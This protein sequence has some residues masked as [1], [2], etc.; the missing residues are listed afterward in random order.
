MYI[1]TVVEDFISPCRL[2]KTKLILKVHLEKI[3]RLIC[4]TILR[5]KVVIKLIKK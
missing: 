5:S 4:I 3:V 2:K 1:F